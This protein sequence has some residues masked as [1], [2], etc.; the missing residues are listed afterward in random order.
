MKQPIW[1]GIYPG[2][3]EITRT[4]PGFGGKTWITNQAAKTRAALRAMRNNRGACEQRGSPLPLLA[5]ALS[6]GQEKISILDFGGGL[7]L[8]YINTRNALAPDVCL[9]YNV[10]E[11]E[12]VCAAGREIFEHDREVE[13]HASLPE[14]QAKIDIAYFGSSLHYVDD[15]QKLLHRI[16]ELETGLILLSDLP[17]GENP[18]YATAQ[19]YYGS[20]IPVWFFNR[21]E[22]ESFMHE[23]GYRL[24]F[25]ARH[26]S[27]ILGR[28]QPLP[29]DNFP[30]EYRVGHACDLLFARE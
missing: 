4:G 23:A 21:A 7:G 25:S 10:V 13:F 8:E 27:R 16:A 20:S 9:A 5:A 18:T 19:H 30:E 17:A 22:V 15:W 6:L 11:V 14:D 3:R 29:Q 2:F 12:E 28:E 26:T 1:Q 24:R